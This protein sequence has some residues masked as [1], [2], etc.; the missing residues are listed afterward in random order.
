MLAPHS[1][2]TDRAATYPPLT[3][4]PGPG[5]GQIDTLIT[6]FTIAAQAMAFRGGILPAAPTAF[7]N[8]ELLFGKGFFD[9]DTEAQ[10]LVMTEL[11]ELAHPAAVPAPL[12]PDP[13]RQATDP[14]Q[15]AVSAGRPVT[16]SAY[17]DNARSL[18]DL[19]LR[20]NTFATLLLKNEIII[21][22]TATLSGQRDDTYARSWT[23]EDGSVV[24]V[25]GVRTD[26]EAFDLAA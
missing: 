22:D 19:M 4:A 2:G 18:V 16:F 12:V 14:G 5:H 11:A 9:L 23:L 6:T 24:S 1:G 15:P 8:T 25:I 21:V 13:V 26:F 3:L 10:L 20:Q 7:Q 17:D